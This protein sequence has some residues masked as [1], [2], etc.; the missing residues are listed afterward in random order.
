M[1]IP[2]LT[3]N[4]VEVRVAQLQQTSY[5]VYAYLLLYKNARVDMK[6]LDEV[7]GPLN[8]QRKHT[9][10][11]F[12]LTICHS[13]FLKELLSELSDLTVPVNQPYLE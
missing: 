4:D 2:L 3:S 13:F 5:G 11:R 6:I 12:S 9:E 7:F 10:I 8:W 1:N